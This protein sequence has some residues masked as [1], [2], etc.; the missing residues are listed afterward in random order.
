MFHFTNIKRIEIIG[1]KFN[2]RKNTTTFFTYSFYFFIFF[3][4]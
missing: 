2:K 1:T 3:Y 4:P